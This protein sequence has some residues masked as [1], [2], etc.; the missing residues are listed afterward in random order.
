MHTVGRKAQSSAGCSWDQTVLTMLSCSSVKM[1]LAE[2][3]IK[4]QNKFSLAQVSLVCHLLQ[5]YLT[6]SGKARAAF[7]EAQ[8]QYKPKSLTCQEKLPS[9]KKDLIE[10]ANQGWK[11]RSARALSRQ[12]GTER[13]RGVVNGR[14]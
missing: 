1:R 8:E 14:G 2:E 13:Y 12:G 11:L 10:F 9:G 3:L 4:G 6:S 7:Q 5:Q